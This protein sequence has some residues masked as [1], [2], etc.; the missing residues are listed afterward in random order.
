MRTP[1][2]AR[3]ALI[4]PI[5]V[6]LETGSILEVDEQQLERMAE[7]VAAIEASPD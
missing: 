6:V 5:D 4:Q 3:D 2:G 7:L 1:R